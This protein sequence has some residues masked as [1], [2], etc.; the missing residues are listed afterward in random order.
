MK[1]WYN[2]QRMKKGFTLVELL[3]VVVVLVT[4]MSIT[5][6]LAGT[7]GSSTAR[8]YTVNRLQRLENCLSGYYAAFGSYPPVKLHGS[9]DYTYEVDMHGIQQVVRRS[10]SG[11]KG[12]NSGNAGSH[13]PELK[14]ENVESA[15]RSQPVG[16]SYPFKEAGIQD[17][18]KKVSEMLIKKAQSS[19]P[20]NKEF[21]DNP[22][23][24]NGFSP[25]VDNSRLT[26]KQG[27]EEW[28]DV[29]IF[30]FGLLSYLLP[31]YLVMLGG[32]QN[33]DQVYSL[34]K[35]WTAN[36]E[37]PCRFED[38]VPY[39]SWKDLNDDI[40]Q[41]KWKVAVLY[42]QAVCARWLPNLEK[43]IRTQYDK[44]YYGVQ[45]RD[46]ADSYANVSA[47]NPRP[48]MYSTS[49]Q[50]GSGS[51]G[52]DQYV[53]DGMTVVDG[54]HHEFYYYSPPPHQTY[55]LWS[56]GANGKTFPPWVSDE[57]LKTLKPEE[58]KQVEEWKSDDIVK[59]SN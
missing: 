21:R 24:L 5:F 28:T 52:G 32:N 44:T 56:A 36:N 37:L 51:G 9:R 47:N 30:R 49:S 1:L 12:A 45:V 54:W 50:G 25:I 38:G 58:Q 15:C 34:Q 46:P 42:S 19:D 20:K 2:P 59:M 26:S 11:L 48:E 14:W 7:G 53:L 29:Q 13:S 23:L 8:N 41:E 33:L 10:S 18:I 39:K 4:L 55:V 43:T 35:Q 22:A 40:R 27:Y 57:E 31:R 16:M 3:I 6:R 17:Y